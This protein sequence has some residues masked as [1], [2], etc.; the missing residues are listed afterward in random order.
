M[1]RGSEGYPGFLAGRGWASGGGKEAG[2]KHW[3]ALPDLC[4][5][6]H[7][8]VGTGLTVLVSSSVCAF[9][10]WV[11]QESEQAVSLRLPGWQPCREREQKERG[12]GASGGDLL[13]YV[14]FKVG[15]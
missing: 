2:D 13:S 5:V 14:E 15:P 8:Y 1:K 9:R 7:G 12:G 4:Q 10:V 6:R 11:A 3:G